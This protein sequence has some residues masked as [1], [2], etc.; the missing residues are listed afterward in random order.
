MPHTS[1]RHIFIFGYVCGGC[2]ALKTM[3]KMFKMFE[4][5]ASVSLFSFTFYAIKYISEPAFTL[6]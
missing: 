2:E 6:R 1:L 4:F 3:E 5:K